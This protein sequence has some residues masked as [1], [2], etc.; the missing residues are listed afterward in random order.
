MDGMTV[1]YHFHT[2]E[3]FWHEAE[4]YCHDKHGG[5]L[6]RIPNKQTDDLIRGHIVSSGAGDV[7]ATGFWIGY[8]DIHTEGQFEWANGGVTCEDYVN[9][10]PNEPNNNTK[11]REEGQDCVQLW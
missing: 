3:M 7:V 10:A 5:I 8:N 1:E 6:A 11:Q 4:E 9:W 2:K